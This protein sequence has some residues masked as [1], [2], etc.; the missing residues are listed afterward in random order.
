MRPR[1]EK[2]KKKKNLIHKFH[3]KKYNKYN[4]NRKIA[5]NENECDDSV[6]VRVLEEKRRLTQWRIVKEQRNLWTLK[7]IKQTIEREREKLWM[8]TW[9]TRVEK[10]LEV[11]CIYYILF[12]AMW[13]PVL[14][15]ESSDWFVFSLLSD[16]CH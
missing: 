13:S 9:E 12:Y 10:S 6:R 16:L 4:E 2:E 15:L 14:V 11:L 1:N 8:C 3:S 7:K 5:V